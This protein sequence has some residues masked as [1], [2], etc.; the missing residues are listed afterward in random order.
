MA[1]NISDATIDVT[2]QNESEISHI[3][4]TVDRYTFARVR[5][6]FQPQEILNIRR[7]MEISFNPKNDR[8]HDP[9]DSD[10]LL[11][12]FQKV[13]VG[14]TQ[15]VNGVPRLVRMFYNSFMD[16]DIF[17]MHQIFRKL[18]RFRN[19]IYNLDS[20]FTLSGIENGMW[21][22][23]RIQHYPRGGG[24][25]AEHVDVGT[26]NVAREMDLQSYI[27]ILLLMSEKGKDFNTGGAYIN[28]DGERFFYESECK[29]GD[30]MIYDGRVNHGVEEIDYL[31]NFE[32]NTLNGR[33]VA[34]TTLFKHMTSGSTDEYK[35][36]LDK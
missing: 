1:F 14:G 10:L 26:A 33:I 12:N 20:E 32:M 36:L 4:K 7:N 13:V 3:R 27:Q 19:Q 9:K 22:A 2:N 5:G 18:A 28:L 34:M 24:F 11:R 15:G 17:K 8:K 31:E 21:S 30:V 29:I 6:I 25:M 35:K 16:D 23:N